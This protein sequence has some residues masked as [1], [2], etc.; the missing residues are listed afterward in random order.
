[1]PPFAALASALPKSYTIT[2]ATPG[3]SRPRAATSVATRAAFGFV[4]SLLVVIF[5][6]VAKASSLYH[7]SLPLC[8][9]CTQRLLLVFPSCNLLT[10]SSHRFFMDEKIM[11]VSPSPSS[12][13][14]NSLRAI[15]FSSSSKTLTTCLMLAFAVNLLSPAPCPMRTCTASAAVNERAVAST[16]LGQVAV[17]NRVWRFVPA[18]GPDAPPAS[19]GKP[20]FGQLSTIFRMSGSKPMSSILSASSRTR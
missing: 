4:L 20:V 13:S 10:K 6:N 8:M 7:W 16:A 14:S 3:I 17:K 5:L 19:S 2:M 11:Q 18:F 1:M 12:F 15:G 9:A